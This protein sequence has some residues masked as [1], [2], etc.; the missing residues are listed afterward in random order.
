[1]KQP[2]SVGRGLTLLH[3]FS[4]SASTGNQTALIPAPS[5]SLQPTLPSEGLHGA[6]LCRC[7]SGHIQTNCKD[8]SFFFCGT[9]G[10]A[11]I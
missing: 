6:T 3:Q 2:H 1:M 11:D 9:F 10:P 7:E 5:T 4:G 8:E